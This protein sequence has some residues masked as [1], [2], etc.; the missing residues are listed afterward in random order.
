MNFRKLPWFD[1]SGRFSPFKTGVFLALFIPGLWTMVSFALDRLGARPVTE[2]IHQFGDW[3]IRLIFISLVISPARLILQW[4]RLL[5]VRRMIGVAACIYVLI[6]L[7][8]YTADEA[9]ALGTVASEIVLRIYLTIGFTA[10]TGLCVLA[11]TSTDGWQRRLGARRWQK[12]HRIV[13]GIGVLAVIHFFLQ[14]KLNEWEPTVMAGILFWL[15]GCRA[16]SWRLGRGKLPLWTV[17]AMSLAA[18]LLTALGEAVYYWLAMGVPIALVL[19]ADLSLDAGLRPAWVVFAA[20]A[21]VAL[22]GWLR[23]TFW[24]SKA[25]RLRPA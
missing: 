10:L 16:V 22:L 3:T 18:G 7:S 5:D 14:S 9:F 20:T 24:P 21:A 15:M 17:A 8:L 19:Q 1:Y 4:P 6:H 2:A 13:Y 11:F 12:L 25:R 23:S